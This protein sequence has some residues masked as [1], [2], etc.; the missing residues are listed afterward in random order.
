MPA[1]I[2]IWTE[3]QLQQ[4]LVDWVGNLSEAD[5]ETAREELTR[6]CEARESQGD[7]NG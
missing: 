3:T 7:K 2:Q 1:A 4:A 6:W 5:R